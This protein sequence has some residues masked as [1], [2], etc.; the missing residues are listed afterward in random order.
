[1]PVCRHGSECL[2]NSPLGKKKKSFLE[3]FCFLTLQIPPR[4]YSEMGRLF[5]SPPTCLQNGKANPPFAIKTEKQIIQLRFRAPVDTPTYH[6]K[7]S[8]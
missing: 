2:V 1:M 8:N 5:K 3:P 6:W 7:P 4:G